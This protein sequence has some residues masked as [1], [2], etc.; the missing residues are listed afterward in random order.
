MLEQSQSG[1][2]IVAQPRFARHAAAIVEVLLGAVL[3]YALARLI[4]FAVFGASAGDVAPQSAGAIGTDTDI[5]R[6]QAAISSL[7]EAPVL[8]VS[9]APTER[10]VATEI[11][12]TQLDLGLRGIRQGRGDR[13]GVAFIHVPGEGDR[14]VAPDQVITDGVV[15]AA[16]EADRVIIRRN[17]VSE[18]LLLRESAEASSSSATTSG[19]P[20]RTAGAMR[21]VSDLFQVA[22]VFQDNALTGYRL[23]SGSVAALSSYGLRPDDILLAINGQNLVETEDVAELFEDL[24]GLDT[25]SVSLRRDGVPL[26]IEVDLP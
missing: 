19:Q 2:S 17:G 11:P 16:I 7:A 10:R 23:S 18:A 26:T 15:L 20:R 1:I 25:L 8:G 3:A 5:G 24:R 9:A 4:W 21:P 6:F 13:P 12:R 22:P 14:I